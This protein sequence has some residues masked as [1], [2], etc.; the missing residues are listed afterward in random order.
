[1]DT[2]SRRQASSASGVIFDLQEL[3]KLLFA[4]KTLKNV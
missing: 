4:H 2:G 1:M 3:K